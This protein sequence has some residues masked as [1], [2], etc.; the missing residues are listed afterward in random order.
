MRYFFLLLIL[1][2]P[3]FLV[4]LTAQEN[5]LSG[6]VTDEKNEALPGANLL[7]KDAP[8]GGILAFAITDIRGR[9]QLNLP[10][11]PDSLWV[12]VT[13]LTQNTA[14]RW[15]TNETRELDWQLQPRTYDLPVMEVTQEAVTRR[16]D[17]L[18]FDVAQLREKSDQSIEQLLQRIPGITVSADGQIS[19]QDLPI[20]KFYIEGLD[21]LEG[22]YAIATRNLSID[23]IRDVE[24]LERHQSIRALDSIVVPPN[25]AI[26]LRLKS[27][28]TFAGTMEG[29]LGLSPALYDAQ[30][31]GFGFTRKQ[32]FNVLGSVNNIGKRRANDYQDFYQGTDFV[33]PLI[34]PSLASIPFGLPTEA[35]LDNQEYTG[36]LSFLRKVGEQTQL[37]LNGLFVADAV[38]YRGQN[39]TTFRD[40]NNE[41]AFDERLSAQQR[42][43]RLN[44]RLLYEINRK[45][46]YLNSTVEIDTDNE[47][48]AGDNF[49]NESPVPERFG[50]EALAVDGG[51]WAI[52]RRKKK[53]F[54]LKGTLGY[55]ERDVAL[56]VSPLTVSVP[57]FP[58]LTLDS[59]RQSARLT[60]LTGD[61]YTSVSSRK[62][63]WRTSGRVGLEF[64]RKTLGSA[65]RN[66]LPGPEQLSAELF[67]NATHQQIV[68]PYLF[69][70]L[71]R[72]S[73]RHFWRINLPLSLDLFTYEDQ[74]RPA[75]EILRQNLLVAKPDVNYN[76][77]F[78]KGQFLSFGYSFA[79]DYARNNQLFEGYILRRNRFF[80]RTAADVN[81]S[82]AHNLSVGLKG[83]NPSLTFR[84]LTSLSAGFTTT[85]LLA[86][87][88]FDASAESQ[89]L[90]Q[91]RNTRRRYAWDN[92][93]VWAVGSNT[94]LRLTTDYAI[95]NY[96]IVLNGRV[97]RQFYD[98]ASLKLEAEQVF[99]SVVFRVSPELVRTFSD[100]AELVQWQ[101]KLVVSYYQQL[102]DGWGATRLQYTYQSFR[103]VDRAVTTNLL[104]LSYE[105]KIFNDNW[106]ISLMARNLLGTET[107]QWLSIDVF[108]VASSSFVLRP[109]QL[110]VS[111]KRAL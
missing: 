15:I 100:L 51:F 67:Q 90:V 49:V 60:S 107:Y 6:T 26:N 65:L 3:C 47:E 95:A 2:L 11:N 77:R 109:R 53:A 81:R 57:D 59:A 75:S 56:A 21:L 32:Q 7:V 91:E 102:P 86:E 19:Y 69:Q 42:V 110:F 76:Y 34:S 108:T 94:E 17:T 83:N 98:Q 12:E 96:P 103:N 28:I 78:R 106:E 73:D 1:L 50:W 64:E 71:K 45:R 97:S 13:H 104:D 30:G 24:I 88:S 9:Y 92:K 99:S 4:N 20:S 41:V 23:A 62:G 79:L 48:T 54:Q 25:A 14:S 55:W 66:E 111:L 29:G 70:E 40:G 46:F 31:T 38:D 33:R 58:L 52:V 10:P 101:E 16:G 93:L 84:Y 36:T 18:I 35:Y 72:E 5:Q 63:K 80:D 22:R 43:N 8:E 89:S 44:G 39:T 85:D 27:S 68:R 37:K 87:A 105:R 61:V 82:R 74:L